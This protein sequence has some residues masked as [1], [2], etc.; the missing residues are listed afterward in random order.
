MGDLSI[1]NKSTLG[2][3]FL[4]LVLIGSDLH[5]LLSC[6]VQR[7]LKG[8]IFIKH[9]IVLFSI[10]I[11]T[12]ILN[13]YTIGSL[14]VKEKFSLKNNIKEN[15]SSEEDENLNKN[16]NKNIIN[17]INYT[18]YS[19]IINSFKYSVYIYILFVLTTKT[20]AFILSIIL[21]LLISSFMT[22]VL[23]KSNDEDFNNLIENHGYI[24]NKEIEN[25]KQKC[26]MNNINYIDFSIRLHN[27]LI[28]IYIIMFILLLLG[29]YLYYKQQRKEKSKNWNWIKFIFGTHNCDN[30]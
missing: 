16:K 5:K 6:S 21:F 11:F 18:D 4:Y 28:I 1:I 10:Y 14:V 17:P 22:Q 7:F 20:D 24:G 26:I 12:F 29:V 25:I 15:F 27:V 3:F 19:Y 9:V 13:W 30:T 23:L 2:L 8:N